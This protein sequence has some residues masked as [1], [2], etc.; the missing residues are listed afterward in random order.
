MAD[1][2]S[3]TA[4]SNFEE[5]VEAGGV[6]SGLLGNRFAGEPRQHLTVDTVDLAAG[7]R[8]EVPCLRPPVRS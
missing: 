5:D 7:S 2:P 4:S 6:W 8:V 3:K 1:P